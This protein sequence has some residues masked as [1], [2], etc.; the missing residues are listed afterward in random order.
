M[1]KYNV[2]IRAFYDLES[3]ERSAYTQ[4]CRSLFL[5]DIG[6][7]LDCY[8]FTHPNVKAFTLKVWLE[9]DSCGKEAK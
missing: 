5:D 1:Q 4:H 9:G 8:M 2:S 6:E 7:W 3:H